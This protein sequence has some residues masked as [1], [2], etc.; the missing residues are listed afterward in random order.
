[1]SLNVETSITIAFTMRRL[2]STDLEPVN[3]IVEAAV[4]S[5]SLPDRVKRLVLP[6]YRYEREDLKHLVMVGAES[7]PGR[8]VGIA[9]WEAAADGDLPSGKTALLLHG[10]YVDPALHGHGVGSRLLEMAVEAAR[11]AGVDGLLVK[12]VRESQGFFRARGLDA[13]PVGDPFRDYP[14]R[15]WKEIATEPSAR[16]GQARPSGAAA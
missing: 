14:Y 11:S 6:V 4:N 2:Q 7:A 9:S 8:V 5:W 10:L 3:A 12:A 13:L 15:Y 1:M 16:A